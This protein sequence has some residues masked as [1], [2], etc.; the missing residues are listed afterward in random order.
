M[1]TPKFPEHDAYER[2]EIILKKYWERFFGKEASEKAKDDELRRT[3]VIIV[4]H[5]LSFASFAAAF[6]DKGYKGEY[7]YCGISAI[8]PV[9]SKHGPAK[10]LKH[11]LRTSTHH[12]HSHSK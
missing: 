2:F 7:P 9:F 11:I 12:L 4:S 5:G 6:S 1:G 8:A 3:V 10:G